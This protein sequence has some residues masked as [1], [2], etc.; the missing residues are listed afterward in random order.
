VSRSPGIGT[1]AVQDDDLYRW[2]K[3]RKIDMLQDQAR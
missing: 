1:S 3:A 2:A